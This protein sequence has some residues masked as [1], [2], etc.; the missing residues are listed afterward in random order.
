MPK[1]L[2]GGSEYQKFTTLRDSFIVFQNGLKTDRDDLFFDFNRNELE[3]RIRRFYGKKYDA[4]F[5]ERFAIHASSSYDIEA[6]R[7]QTKFSTASIHPCLYRPFDFRWIYYDPD[8][9]SRPATKVMRHQLAG[10]NLALVCLRQT[11]RNEEGTFLVSQKLINKDAVSLFDIGTVFPLYLYDAT[12]ASDTGQNELGFA[13]GQSKRPNLNPSFLRTVAAALQLPQKGSHGLPTGLTPEDIF[14]YGYAV[15]HSPGY[16]TRY[17]EFLKIDFPRLPLTGDLELFR[18]L[19][20]L[21]GELV[22]LHLLESRKLAELLTEFIGDRNPEVKKVSWS[23]NTV[24]VDKAQTT[25]FKGVREPVWNFHIGGYQVC[26]KW[27]K[28][29]KGRKLLKADIEHYQKIVVALAETIRLMKEI[30]EVIEAH[31]GWPGAFQTAAERSAPAAALAKVIPFRPRVVE[32]RPEER[33]V[34]CVPLVPLKAAAG[35]FSDPQHIE[36]DGWKW[37]AVDTKH[38]LRAGMFVA[39]VVGKSMEPAISDGSYCLFAAPVAG[40]RQGKTVLVQLRD[41]TDSETGERYTVKRYESEKAKDDD[42]WRHERITLK[43]IN[44]DFEPIM[45]TGADEGALQVIAEL[46]EV[47]AP[48]TPT[49]G[50]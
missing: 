40:T 10:K 44:A 23:R 12:H 17:A 50:G 45:L 34:T 48:G 21:G 13:R 15:F 19:A 46:V 24:W 36:D 25:G 4:E 38:R 2:S 9:T 35:A 42:S 3:T 41:A 26:E 22:S 43:P 27:L 28:D 30:D 32:P 20:R 37:A 31:G 11:R 18:A 16:R 7:D 1:D 29:R 33:Y 6:R 47:L 8:L 5:A 39:Q 49:E 14:N